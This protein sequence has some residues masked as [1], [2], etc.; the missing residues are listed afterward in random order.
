MGVQRGA[1]TLS[2]LHDLMIAIRQFDVFRRQHPQILVNH[3][4]QFEPE[5]KRRTRPV[6]PCKR[7]ACA[8]GR[9]FAGGKVFRTHRHRA[10]DETCHHEAGLRICMDH[11]RAYASASRLAGGN[12]FMGRG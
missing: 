3:R 4:E 2:F 12:G 5:G 11:F 9:A 10:F 6:Q 7:L 8:G 1:D